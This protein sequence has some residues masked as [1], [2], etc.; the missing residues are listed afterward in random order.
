[1]N[2][3]FLKSGKCGGLASWPISS[4]I[5]VCVVF[6]LM[7][8]WSHLIE[9]NIG[10]IKNLSEAGAYSDKIILGADPLEYLEYFRHYP[11]TLSGVS[12]E[13]VYT[14]FHKRPLYGPICST[15]S[16]FLGTVLHIKY[17]LN[18]ILILAAY[19]TSCSVLLYLLLCRIVPTL[20]AVAFTFLGT[21]SFGWLSLFSIPESYSLTIFGALLALMSGLSFYKSDDNILH[22]AALRHSLVVGIVSWLYLPLAGA[23]LLV[24][25]RVR[26]LKALI[27]ILLPVIAVV[28]VI[29]LVPQLIEKGGEGIEYQI[30]YGHRWGS[31]DYITFANFIDVLI[32]FLFFSFLSPVYDFLAAKGSP[33]FTPQ[34]FPYWFS[35]I[36]LMAF[37]Y[38]CLLRQ[39]VKGQNWREVGGAIAWL[40][41]LTLFYTYYNPSEALLYVSLPATIIVYIAATS[42]SRTEFVASSPRIVA[43]Y[44]ISLGLL[45]LFV[46]L[47]SIL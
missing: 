24:L 22:F 30:E 15:I 16:L 5:F 3:T 40:I 27:C 44:V 9:Y 7:A 43:F 13:N 31:V 29:A 10:R 42:I 34:D 14:E 28:V 46:N 26:S 38:L 12:R 8:F 18:M 41:T 11:T 33:E 1:M 21:S 19:A 23:A 6:A 39:L 35:S 17:P 2:D 37:V 25:T 4:A 36:V 45:A 32:S 47:S 20:L